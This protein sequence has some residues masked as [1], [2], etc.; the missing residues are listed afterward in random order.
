GQEVIFENT[1]TVTGTANYLWDFGDGNSSTLQNPTHA[2]TAIYDSYNVT[3]KVSYNADCENS[4]SKSIKVIEAPVLSI[5]AEGS[6]TFCAGDS[7]K[8]S[9][10]SIFKNYVWTTGDGK[11]ITS[12]S[13]Y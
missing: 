4:I 12:P 6:T 5:T 10:P 1:S 7:V 11:S 9:V 3:L 13:V 2:Y 8:L